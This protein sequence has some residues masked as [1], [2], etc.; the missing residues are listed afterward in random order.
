[1]TEDDDSEFN[2]TK[3]LM[4]KKGFTWEVFEFAR[5]QVSIMGFWR[6]HDGSVGTVWKVHHTHEHG[7]TVSD[8]NFRNPV[9][10]ATYAT[11]VYSKEINKK[12]VT[13]IALLRAFD[14]TTISG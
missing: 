12:A 6:L 3:E 2:K 9:A 14:R 7:S 4:A 8:P 11:R 13:P 5:G 1:M 10:A